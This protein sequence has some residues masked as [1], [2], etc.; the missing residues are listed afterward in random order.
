M[1]ATLEMKIMIVEDEEDARILLANLLKEEGHTVLSALKGK[2]ALELLKNF[3][4]DLVITDIMMPELDGFDFCRQMKSITEWA[5]I[6][7]IFYTATYISKEDKELGM[8]MGASRFIIKPQEPDVLLELINDV[9]NE[10]LPPSQ[11]PVSSNKV[12][13][14]K[15]LAT[16]GEK[17]KK[18][19]KEL[20]IV[21]S[22]PENGATFN[23][24][25][26]LKPVN[27]Q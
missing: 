13:N 24:R 9:I 5:H 15:Q 6:P 16:V 11:I 26:P 10:K 25:L 21:K 7:I 8:L 20:E 17:L 1:V 18:K 12:I 2:N 27:S 14:R 3:V 23:V 4:P 22:S 19:I